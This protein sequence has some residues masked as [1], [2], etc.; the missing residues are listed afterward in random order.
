MRAV[1]QRVSSA[2]VAIGGQTKAAISGGLLIL[3][4]IEA[5]DG[6]ILGCT[7]IELLLPTGAADLSPVPLFP[8]SRIH[9]LAAVELAL[10]DT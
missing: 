5:A 6:I 3:L 7:E 9:A 1:I 4:A 2:S 8:T 10:A